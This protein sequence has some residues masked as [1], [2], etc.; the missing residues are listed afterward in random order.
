MKPR[1]QFGLDAL[2]G[3]WPAPDPQ[4]QGGLAWEE[5][6]EKIVSAAQALKDQGSPSVLDA[7][8]AA[9]ALE[10][11]PGEAQSQGF[12]VVAPA[13]VVEL[14]AQPGAKAS[15]QGKRPSLK[16]L[17]ARANQTRGSIPPGAT[18]TPPPPGSATVTPIA[19]ARA[20]A[21]GAGRTSNAGRED[22]G[23]LRLA[24]VQPKESA[25]E[26]R[27]STPGHEP[28]DKEAAQ[29]VAAGAPKP[30]AAKPAAAPPSNRTGM[31]AGAAIA[32]L[33]IAAAFAL[34]K[35]RQADPP[36]SDT[37]AEVKPTQTQAPTAAIVT[38]QP[39]GVAQADPAPAST[40][41]PKAD[42]SKGAGG[43]PSPSS[44]AVASADLKP[45]AS[46]KPKGEP[47]GTLEEEMKKRV[48]ATDLPTAPQD[49]GSKPAAGGGGNLPEQPSQGNAQAA[50][51][52]VMGGAKACVAGAPEPSSAS[53]TF[54]SSGSVQSVSVGGWAAANGK[55]G[56]VKSALQG[57]HVAPFAKPSF[58]VPV[59]IRP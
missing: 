27:A 34:F 30:V 9:P 50:V 36:K 41:A 1:D 28:A 5:R 56:C 3:R 15:D 58:T 46:A 33:G 37:V 42:D 2:L 18:S 40:D 22:S 35:T 23:I 17:A 10:A 48:G 53:I 31:W 29:V 49:D 19:K 45:S 39:T 13:P 24:D 32:V 59:T 25:N 52:A 4:E 51:R 16:E 43:A 54:S 14:P 57:A 8:T 6:A 21:S 47:V 20:S 44:T 55:S 7:L 26:S 12:E 38:A 11:E